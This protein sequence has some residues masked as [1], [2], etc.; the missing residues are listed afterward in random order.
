MR[1]SLTPE[2][3]DDPD[4]PQETW[5][6]FHRQ[7]SALH[8]FLGNQ[9]AILDALRRHPSPIGRVLDIGCGDGELLNAIQRDL[10]VEVQGVDLRPPRR[11][12]FDVPIVAADAARDRLP[13]AD[14]AVC[15][16][17]FH[18]LS[19][20]EITALVRN[21]SRSVRRLIV[22]DLVRHRLPLVLFTILV[23]PFLMRIV[24]LDGCQSIRRAYTPAEL[25]GIVEAAL[26]GSGARLAHSVTPFRSRQ[27]IDIIWS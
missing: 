16:T 21:A 11:Q 19:E 20:D 2:I 18:H 10:R 7:L 1:R 8:R 5:E 15:V 23:A 12:I 17:V 26:A 4:I 9:R 14:V 22:L 24:A 27:V 25:R 3:M 13:D 6:R